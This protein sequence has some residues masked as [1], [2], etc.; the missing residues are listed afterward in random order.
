MPIH[1]RIHARHRYGDLIATRSCESPPS[2]KTS[3]HVPTHSPRV[4]PGRYRVVCWMPN[5]KVVANARDPESALVL[6]V[7]FGPPVET[8][9]EVEVWAGKATDA[10]L[11]VPSKAFR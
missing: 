1:E 6:R 2:A 5:W 7:T 8:M 9:G 4:P 11:N 3:L 10:Q